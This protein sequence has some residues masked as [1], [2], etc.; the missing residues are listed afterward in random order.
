MNQQTIN[1]IRIGADVFLILLLLGILAYTM[2]YQQDVKEA[3]GSKDPDRLMK[4]YE[5]KTN[6]K[7]L[8]ANPK[9]G[10]VT[11]ID[12]TKTNQLP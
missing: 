10:Y 4:L 9:Y 11:F 1:Y 5:E 7:C 12:T 8:C 6:R 2:V 3:I